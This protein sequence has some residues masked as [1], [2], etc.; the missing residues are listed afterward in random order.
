MVATASRNTAQIRQ[1]VFAS[2]QQA[3]SLALLPFNG[4]TLHRLPTSANSPQPQPLHHAK[5]K[6]HFGHQSDDPFAA[7]TESHGEQ[8]HTT[9][10]NPYH[11]ENHGNPHVHHPDL[12]APCIP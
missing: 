10:H 1:S 11:V 12:L 9:P 5:Q 4:H 6:Y 8:K 2:G 7:A 3:S